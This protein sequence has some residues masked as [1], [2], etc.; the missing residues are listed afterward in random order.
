M[1]NNQFA[2]KTNSLWPKNK[3]EVLQVCNKWYNSNVVAVNHT[4]IANLPVGQITPPPVGETNL[5]LC[6]GTLQEAAEFAVAM[7]SINYMFWSKDTNGDFVRYQN[8]N[9]I[10]A[11][12]MCEAFKNAWDDPDSP[13]SKARTG[14]ELTAENIVQMFG[15]IPAP[16]SRAAVLNEV[17]CGPQLKNFA[18]NLEN[19]PSFTTETAHLLADLF[20]TAYGDE[21]LKKSQ[22]AVSAIWREARMRGS[23]QL[24]D[25]T[26]FADYQIPNVLRALGVLTYDDQL[27]AR[28]DSGALIEENSMEERAI[29]AAS[30][31]A[32]EELAKAQNVSVADVDYWIWLKRKEPKTPFH[33]TITTAY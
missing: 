4:A 2:I 9:Q 31:L 10:G 24:C 7:N 23:D 26:A 29:R 27:A 11:L 22:L 17:L 12:A 30:I 6:V 28:I 3:N 16:E 20:P 19:N 18:Q 13:L 21:V 1:K 25:V 32:V 5:E 33:L 14:I 8:N 15:D